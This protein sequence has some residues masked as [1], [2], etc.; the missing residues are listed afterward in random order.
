MARRRVGGGK[1]TRVCFLDIETT[2]T[3]A[4]VSMVTGIGIL[5][6]GGRF[7]FIQVEKPEDEKAGLEKALKIL[8]GY[9]VVFTWR[10]RD[11]DV[12]FIVA[13]ALKHGVDPSPLYEVMHLDLADF[14]RSHMRLSRTDLYNVARFL[15]IKKDVA[16]QGRDMPLTYLETLAREKRKPWRKI[17]EHCRDDL[18]TLMQVYRRLKPLLKMLKPELAL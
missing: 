10:G 17:R 4:D 5:E 12:P 16:T 8:S 9:D 14:T 11:F 2:G 6:E 13:R 3:E 15:G 18:V 7:M 1:A